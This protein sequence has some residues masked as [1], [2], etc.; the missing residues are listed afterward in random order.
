MRRQPALWL[1]TA[2]LAAAPTARAA[3]L[4]EARVGTE[5]VTLI[6]DAD[7]GRV[8]LTGPGGARLVD[9]AS[10]TVYLLAP[11]A[12]P[13]MIRVGKLDSAGHAPPPH[14]AIEKVGVGPRVAGYPTTRFRL[15]VGATLCSV[16][17][18]NLGLALKLA[19]AVKALDL[20]DRL[21][22]ARGGDSRSVCEHVPYRRYKRIGWAMRV[23]DSNA[24]AMEVVA[25]TADY[26]PA[27]GAL[28]LPEAAQ[29][30]TA[31]VAGGG[32]A[33]RPATTPGIEANP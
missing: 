9:L 14:V 21:D 20:L 25:V 16:I 29:D 26:K 33:A 3:V 28:D 22:E 31:R 10:K 2:M 1:L 13:R 7:A 27:A 8:R 17:D 15:R 30:L 18:A 12:P 6:S 23:Q 24:P 11:G 19:P 5:T 4:L 32:G